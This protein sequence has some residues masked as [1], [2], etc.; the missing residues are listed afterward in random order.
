MQSLCL[1][2]HRHTCGSATAQRIPCPVIFLCTLSV[3]NSPATQHCH[4]TTSGWVCSKCPYGTNTVTRKHR[5]GCVQNARMVPQGYQSSRE[6][7]PSGPP[8]I[9]TQNLFSSTQIYIFSLHQQLHFRTRWRISAPP[10]VTLAGPFC[11]E[12]SMRQQASLLAFKNVLVKTCLTQHWPS[13]L[14]HKAQND[15]NVANTTT[16]G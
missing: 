12:Q 14:E 8:F 15:D 1:V 13:L 16:I 2:L 4:S 10:P 11:R 5:S 9:F 7:R 3:S 6:W